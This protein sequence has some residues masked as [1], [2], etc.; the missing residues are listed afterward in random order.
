MNKYKQLMEKMEHLEKKV[1]TLEFLVNYDKDDIV[2]DRS[3]EVDG[4]QTL[5]AY[6]VKYLNSNNEVVKN[7]VIKVFTGEDEELPQLRIKRA[8]GAEFVEVWHHDIL[9]S[10]QRINRLFGTLKYENWTLYMTA[11]YKERLKK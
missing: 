6:S 11:Y 9:S 4:K 3:L 2:I 10:V 1:E 7:D 8:D 5:F